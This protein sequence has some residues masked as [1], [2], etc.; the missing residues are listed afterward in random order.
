MQA[1]EQQT[2]KCESRILKEYKTKKTDCQ[3]PETYYGPTDVG[4][5][6]VC[7]GDVTV[8][9]RAIAEPDWGGSHP[10]MEVDAVCTKC[11]YPWWPGKVEFDNRVAHYDGFDITSYLETR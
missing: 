1:Q 10:V 4:T 11:K 7:G 6:P 2:M 9:L 8:K 3:W 5:L